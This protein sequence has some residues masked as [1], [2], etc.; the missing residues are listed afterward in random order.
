MQDMTQ[1]PAAPGEACTQGMLTRRG[2]GDGGWRERGATPADVHTRA[3]R[4][5]LVAALHA[6]TRADGLDGRGDAPQAGLEPLRIRPTHGLPPSRGRGESV[7]DVG[8]SA[9][10]L[11]WLQLKSI[12]LWDAQMD[13]KVT[14]GNAH[15]PPVILM[16]LVRKIPAMCTAVVK[17][18]TDLTHC[19][20]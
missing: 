2:C 1:Q 10:L 14:P 3:E 13:G 19:P 20:Q 18:R 7:P 15:R 11:G 4:R 12:E 17:L 8:S 6:D 16:L 5:G 9:V